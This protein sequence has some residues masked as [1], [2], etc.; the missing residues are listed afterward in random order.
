MVSGSTYRSR[1]SF[2]LLFVV[3]TLLLYVNLLPLH[4]Q[5]PSV[6]ALK[7]LAHF[8]DVA[9]KA[10]LAAPVTFGGVNTKKYII[11]TTGT[12]VAVFDYDND[13]WPDIFIVNGTTLENDR[14]SLP[15]V[16]SHLYHNNHD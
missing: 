5:Q 15:P 4:S 3:L 6:S 10:G 11:E 1:L 16:T 12:G 2:L 13:G 14:L 8:T 7:P 9:R